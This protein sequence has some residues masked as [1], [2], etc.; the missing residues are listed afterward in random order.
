MNLERVVVKPYE[1]SLF[2]ALSFEIEIS[3]T[4][5][6][7]TILCVNG[8]IE[9]DDRKMIGIGSLCRQDISKHGELGAKELPESSRPSAKDTWNASLIVF[10]D[11]ISLDHIETRR[12]QDKKGDVRLVLNLEVI[13]AESRTFVSP[14]YGIPAEKI[15]LTVREIHGQYGQPTLYSPVIHI[16]SGVVPLYHSDLKLLSPDPHSS[17]FLSLRTNTF[18]HETRIP[19]TD[20]IQDYSPRLGLGEFFVFQMGRGEKAIKDAWNYIEKAQESLSL[21]ITK[22]VYGNC[23]D[24]GFLLD[25]T[26]RDKIGQ[27]S[28]AYQEKW[29]RTYNNFKHLASLDLHLEEH[30]KSEKYGSNNVVVT[31]AD[32]EHVLLIAKMMVKNA[33]ELLRE[34]K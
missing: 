18:S 5:Y 7:E 19:S 27:N 1:Q 11:S 10:L 3:V 2:S 29:G 9:T 8:W 15:G 21:G 30:R 25:R 4:R 13:S 33:D 31:S 24:M 12:K 20:W 16:S 22:G 28:F 26:L 23:R 6:E 32:A 14:V 17:V 34:S